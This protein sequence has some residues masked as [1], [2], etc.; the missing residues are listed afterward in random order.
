M[1]FKNTTEFLSNDSYYQGMH[2]SITSVS[3]NWKVQYR[4]EIIVLNSPNIVYT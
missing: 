4:T 2:K 3:V 1:L